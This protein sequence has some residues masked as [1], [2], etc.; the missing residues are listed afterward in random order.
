[1]TK[2]A[3]V[4]ATQAFVHKYGDNIMYLEDQLGV[5]PNADKS[6]PI[7]IYGSPVQP[8][9]GDMAWNKKRG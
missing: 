4:A 5:I 2:E 7:F 3:G 1:L 6:E 8:V 9:F